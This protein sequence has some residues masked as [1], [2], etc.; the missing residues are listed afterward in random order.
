M[1]DERAKIGMMPLRPGSFVRAEILEELGLSV[2]R[3]ADI[4][5]APRA[6]LSDHDEGDA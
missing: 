1:G 3:T 2:Y 6:T 4:L 5:C